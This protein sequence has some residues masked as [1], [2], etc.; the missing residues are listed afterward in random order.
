M[1]RISD[2][3]LGV[4]GADARQRYEDQ[5]SVQLG[6]Q[7]PDRDPGDVRARVAARVAAAVGAGVTDEAV[8]T[9]YVATT[10]AFDPMP[11]PPDPPAQRP[12]REQ[13]RDPAS[14][15]SR[16]VGSAVQSCLS[17]IAIELVDDEGH[18]IP[19]EAFV[20]ELPDGTKRRGL[21]DGAGQAMIVG[22]AKG[23]CKVSFPDTQ[24]KA[25]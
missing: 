13:R 5:L 6:G 4:L 1:L 8:V 15:S 21:T 22:V 10:F 23:T 9:R 24:T 2:D 25:K 16:T 18:P 17:F 20:I 11:A 14:Q 12:M 19:D 3:Q 7:H